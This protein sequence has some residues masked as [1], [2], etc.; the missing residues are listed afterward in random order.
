MTENRVYKGALRWI[1]LAAVSLLI[2]AADQITKYLVSTKMYIG[3]EIT[4]IP[5][6]FKLCYVRNRGAGL[7]ILAN[8]RWVFLTATVIIIAIIIILLIRNFFKSAL[9]DVSMALVFAGGV[10]NMIDRILMG[11]VVDFF[12]FQIKLFDFIFNVADIAVTFGAIIFIIYYLFFAGKSNTD[13]PD[14]IEQN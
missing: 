4:V 2:I 1:I 5:G 10:G 6:F 11:E 7:G 14:G 3:E 13:E 8:A 12:Q 9:A